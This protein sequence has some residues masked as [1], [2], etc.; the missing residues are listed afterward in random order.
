MSLYGTLVKQE[1]DYTSLLDEKIPECEKLV[2]SGKLQD[3]IEILMHLEKQA[4][5][6]SALIFLSYYYVLL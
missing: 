5:L 1:A 4:R 3:A 2:D 6:V